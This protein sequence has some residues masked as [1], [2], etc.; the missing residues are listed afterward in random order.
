MNI[1]NIGIIN[2][3]TYIKSFKA[4]Y[5]CKT[6]RFGVFPY[7]LVQYSVINLIHPIFHHFLFVSG[8]KVGECKQKARVTGV[9]F[10]LTRSF[11]FQDNIGEESD[12]CNKI[13]LR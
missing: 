8:Q 7:F 1:Y 13:N 12:N 11:L 3:T 6:R 2:Q 4:L 9:S 5:V 10:T